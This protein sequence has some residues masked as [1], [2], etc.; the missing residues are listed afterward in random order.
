MGQ[1]AT[2]KVTRDGSANDLLR[3][4]IDV[5]EVK[6]FEEILPNMNDIFIQVVNDASQKTSQA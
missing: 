1:Q 5:T 2:I 6:A 4:L 3:K